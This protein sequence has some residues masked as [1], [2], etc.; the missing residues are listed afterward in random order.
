MYVCVFISLPFHLI[1]G[2]MQNMA[3]KKASSK[4]KSWNRGRRKVPVADN[5]KVHFSKILWAVEAETKELK[6]K[7][8]LGYMQSSRAALPKK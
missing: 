1:P 7:T 5:H 2:A 4:G 3:E 8:S 6:F